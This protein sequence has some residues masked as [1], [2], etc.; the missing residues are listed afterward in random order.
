MDMQLLL[1]FLSPHTE[2]Y[3]VMRLNLCY[4]EIRGRNMSK[5]IMIHQRAMTENDQR[6]TGF[7][8]P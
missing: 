4:Q 8:G 3:S 2:K 5:V 1:D 6:T 7:T